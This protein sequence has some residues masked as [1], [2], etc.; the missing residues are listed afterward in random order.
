MKKW[1][2]GGA[3]ALLPLAYVALMYLTHEPIDWTVLALMSLIVLPVII[4]RKRIDA[5]E[6]RVNA[7]S[8]EEK[9]KG[10]AKA[11]AKVASR[12]LGSE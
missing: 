5:T 12:H 6:K 1:I 8:D 11:V 4:F 2:Y 3:L 7:M 10:V 9:L